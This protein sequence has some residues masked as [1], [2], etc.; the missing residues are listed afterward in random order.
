VTHARF[1]GGMNDYV[2][3]TSSELSRYFAI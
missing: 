1:G 2:R 3:V